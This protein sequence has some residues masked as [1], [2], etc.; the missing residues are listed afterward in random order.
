MGPLASS[1]GWMS[2]SV[3][4]AGLRPPFRL[5]HAD[6]KEP[7]GQRQFG[8]E[9][10][11]LKIRDRQCEE[12]LEAVDPVS[13]AGDDHQQAENWRKK[14]RPKDEKSNQR[15]EHAEERQAHAEG[16]AEHPYRTARK[17]L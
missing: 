2:L 13:H 12:E 5:V 10:N 11:P 3:A 9:R 4:L 8:D 14:L 16:I 17:G 6:N 1:I 15:A 7:Q